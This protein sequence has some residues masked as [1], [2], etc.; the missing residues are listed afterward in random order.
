M[1]LKACFSIFL[2]LECSLRLVLAAHSPPCPERL[3]INSIPGRRRRTFSVLNTR[4]VHRGIARTK[5]QW[6]MA[7]NYARRLYRRKERI[8]IKYGQRILTMLAKLRHLI[9]SYIIHHN[10]YSLEPQL[11]IVFLRMFSVLHFKL[12]HT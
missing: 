2:K 8:D 6:S 4:A 5:L 7:G 9:K 10:N 11:V 3:Q 1:L 12:H